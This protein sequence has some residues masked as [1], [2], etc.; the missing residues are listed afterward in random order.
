MDH[1]KH[2]NPIHRREEGIILTNQNIQAWLDVGTALSYK[3]IARQHNLTGIAFYTQTLGI[4]VTSVAAGA[5]AFFVCHF[6]LT[7]L[8]GG[9]LGRGRGLFGSR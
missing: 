7:L 1:V 5:A 9:F 3:Y 6:Y 8:P 2:D 4:A